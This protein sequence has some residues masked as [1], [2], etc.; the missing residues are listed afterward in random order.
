MDFSRIKSTKEK[1]IITAP[2]RYPDQAVMTVFAHTEGKRSTL[3]LNR[4]ALEMMNINEKSRLIMFDQFN[5][6]ATD[7]PFYMP[8]ICITED[9][10][11]QGPDK[12][13][14]SYDIHPNTHCVKSLE[15]YNMI[16]SVFNLDYSTQYDLSINPTAVEGAFTLSVITNPNLSEEIEVEVNLNKGEEVEVIEQ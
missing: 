2:E 11:V 5:T 14:K 7:E 4:S 8:V 16:Q 15:I 1:V 12:Q 13:H 6:S 9:E 3:K 10:K